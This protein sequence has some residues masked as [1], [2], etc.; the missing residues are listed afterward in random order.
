MENEILLQVPATVTK[1][2]SMRNSS[3]RIQVDTQEGLTG[4]VKAKVMG[5]HEKYGVF[6]FAHEE[7]GIDRKDLVIPD[8]EPM[9]KGEKSLSQRQRAVLFLH[10]KQNGKKD[11]YGHECSADE[12]YR[13][14]M[15]QIID[16]LKSKLE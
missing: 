2:T 16:H 13:Q 15:E 3:L 4:L 6:A 11:L 10:W 14:K 12:Y 8:F 9:E 7:K 5:Y 1:V